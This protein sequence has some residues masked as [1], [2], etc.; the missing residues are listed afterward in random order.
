MQN[1]FSIWFCEMSS[2]KASASAKYS[3]EFKIKRWKY[4]SDIWLE[5]TY[6]WIIKKDR[7][8]NKILKQLNQKK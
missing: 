5:M 4:K 1:T 7:N 6:M 2:S 8:I 3:L